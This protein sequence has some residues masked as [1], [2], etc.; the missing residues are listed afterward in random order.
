MTLICKH[1]Q[2]ELP[3]GMRFCGYCGARLSDLPLYLDAPQ[4]SQIRHVTVLFADLVGY[5]SAANRLDS[6][7]LYELVQQ[8]TDLLSREVYKYEGII[9]KMTGDG[10]MALFGAPVSYEN[11]TERAVRA[12]LDMQANF[13]LWRQHVQQNLNLD[14]NL[15]IGLH[16]GP[17]IVGEIGSNIVMDYTAI[18][19]TVNL[20]YRLQEIAEPGCIFTS[21]HVVH[22]TK[23]IFDYE[24]LPDATLKGFDHPIPCYRLI[25]LKPLA[26]T[27]RAAEGLHAPLIGR[28]KE[29][30]H[31]L[32]AAHQ[33]QSASQ[34]KF[35]LICGE[36]GIGKSRLLQEFKHQ[37]NEEKLPYLEGYSLT[38]RR[39]VPYWIFTDLLRRRLGISSKS[40]PSEITHRIS[41]SLQNC[42]D[43]QTETLVPYIEYLF[44]L[45]SSDANYLLLVQNL[46][47]QQLRQQI[48]TAIRA[49]LYPC[50]PNQAHIWILEDLQWADEVSLGILQTVIADLIHTPLLILAATR[51]ENIPTLQK[52]LK[53][54]ESASPQ[55]F[56]R[57]ELRSL[58]DEESYA[59]LASLVDIPQFPPKL[60]QNILEHAAGIPLYLEEILRM[61]LDAGALIHSPS[62]LRPHRS[63]DGESLGVPITL[64]GLIQARFDQ[65]DPFQ[66]TV[67]QSASIIGHHFSRNLLEAILPVHTEDLQK[68]LQELIER[69]FIVSTPDHPQGEFAFRH[70]MISEAVYNTLLKKERSRLHAL[71]GTAIESQ[72][73]G[74]LNEVIELLARHFSW[75][76]QPEKALHYLI[77]AAQKAIAGSLYEQAQKH[78]EHAL[79]LLPNVEAAHQQALQVHLGLGDLYQHLGDT[80]SARVQ[81]LAAL[82][83]LSQMASP[84]V[85]EIRNN[86][87]RKLRQLTIASPVA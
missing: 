21:A 77:L 85:Q 76:N 66:R 36:A 22:Q 54:V 83:R 16:C 71:V 23:T 34:G 28:Q 5:T 50:Y 56:E 58:T 55:A 75:G 61:L 41:Q 53:A 86:L 29:L 40:T 62:G 14:L 52:F 37:L 69:E 3:D 74:R 46:E 81:Y 2:A 49:I 18:G 12:A 48:L 13:L 25:G 35:I 79:T 6:E 51:S 11:N 33:I 42:A 78:Y 70:L 19:E 44:S 39:S 9:D 7:A 38:Y 67:L 20:A 64:Q 43:R 57:I 1:C 65:L 15:R 4:R 60:I 32:Q 24:R 45:P 17:V 30:D 8:Y 27:T 87:L 10:I 31:L 84:E 80:N 59:L 26:E 82:D 63:I 68:T 73:S 47:A 72:Y